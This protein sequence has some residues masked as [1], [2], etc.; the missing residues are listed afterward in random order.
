MHADRTLNPDGRSIIP[1][2]ASKRLPKPEC[3]QG[4]GVGWEFTVAG[5]VT[6]QLEY[7]CEQVGVL[8]VGQRS[9]PVVRH[10]GA[11]VTEELPERLSAPPHLEQ[12]PAELS[13]PMA[14]GAGPSEDGLPATSLGLGVK[15]ACT[16]ASGGGATGLRRR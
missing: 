1:Y 10:T 14:G 16:R 15:G 6:I 4:A 9:R 11:D 7:V 13:W 8:L 2:F 5:G 3:A 12:S